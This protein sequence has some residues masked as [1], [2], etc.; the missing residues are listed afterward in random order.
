M[1]FYGHRPS[2]EI[3]QQQAAQ[4]SVYVPTTLTYDDHPPVA[5]VDRSGER[6]MSS[7]VSNSPVSV[8][9]VSTLPGNEQFRYLYN[10][11]AGR[12][13]PAQS[14]VSSALAES[15]TVPSPGTS[16]APYHTFNTELRQ[17]SLPPYAAVSQTED[18]KPYGAVRD[19][20]YRQAANSD[21][22]RSMMM[23]SE[24]HPEHYDNR[25]NVA[26]DENAGESQLARPA[27]LEAG[28]SSAL[29][30]RGASG[31]AL[32][33]PASAPGTNKKTVTFHE[34]IAT[35]YA[36]HHSYGSTSSE[37]SFALPSPP[38][39]AGG[40]DPVMYQGPVYSYDTPVPR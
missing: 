40:Y 12:M 3:H 20:A 9:A 7:E 24:Y 16:Y 2:D 18:L 17:G 10:W 36:F 30:V 23:T 35:E 22:Q 33:Q 15:D 4:P 19:D 31:S 1:C 13:M 8:T 29:P 26:D 28:T 25:Q 14:T 5:A 34:N 39:M 11:E 37:N 32:R 38:V 6:W 27:G 21:M